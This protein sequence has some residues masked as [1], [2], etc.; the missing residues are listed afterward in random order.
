MERKNLIV[1]IIVALTFFCGQ[2]TAEEVVGVSIFPN[3]ETP[4]PYPEPVE[5]N[6]LV[7]STTIHKAGADWLKV[8]FSEFRLNPNDYV[9]L[10]DMNGNLVERIRGKDVAMKRRSKFNVKDSGKKTVSFWGPAIDGDKL[11]VELHRTSNMNQDFGFIIDEVGVGSKPLKPERRLTHSGRIG[12]TILYQ[13]GSTWYT[14][15]GSLSFTD[16]NRFELSE[17]NIDARDIIDTLEVRFFFEYVDVKNG[18]TIPVYYTF[19]CERI[20]HEDLDD[21]TG[22]FRLRPDR[23]MIQINP[24][25]GNPG[26]SAPLSEP[27]GENICICS[28]VKDP[29]TL[30]EWE[31]EEFEPPLEEAEEIPSEEEKVIDLDLVAQA[32]DGN[33][34]IVKMSLDEDGNISVLD[35]SPSPECSG[36][37]DAEGVSRTLAGP[38]W[39]VCCYI[40][41]MVCNEFK[42]HLF[43]LNLNCT[44]CFY[45]CLFKWV[46]NHCHSCGIWGLSWLLCV[47]F[48][49]C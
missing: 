16:G 19:Y 32:D 4:Y 28:G 12:E 18:N 8:H 23:D 14:S 26:I 15:K 2:L 46:D 10:T 7:W 21:D 9:T 27:C 47:W 39:P 43:W 30:S 31:T 36:S 13:R 33:W 6:T 37:Q 17:A 29:I 35:K 11:I 45:N 22:Q 49:H 25:G 41:Y 44:G 1:M 38:W 3:I 40:Q 42:K 5:D 20:G 48:G 34:Y 24:R